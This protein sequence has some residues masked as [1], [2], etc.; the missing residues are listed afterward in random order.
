MPKRRV[1]LIG[2]ALAICLVLA[3]VAPSGRRVELSAETTQLLAAGVIPDVISGFTPDGEVRITVVYGA[4]EVLSG[5]QL[6]PQEAAEAPEVAID[7]DGLFTLVMVDLD[8][9]SPED[10]KYREWLH[11]IVADINPNGSIDKGREIVEYSGPTP[12]QGRHR[13]V[14]LV[15]RQPDGGMQE[16]PWPPGAS[17]ASFRVEQWAAKKGLEGPVAVTYFY[18]SAAS[19]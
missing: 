16:E 2:G 3:F 19:E 1:L 17:R 6:A 15:Y 12:P 9:P 14:L 4:A 5:G 11:W 10:P 8:P 13:Y 18:A 7:G